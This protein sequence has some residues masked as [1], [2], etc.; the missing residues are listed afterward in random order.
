MQMAQRIKVGLLFNY[1]TNWVAG[2]YYILNLIHAV[3]KL[4]DSHKPEFTILSH[5]EDEFKIARETGYPYLSFS[6]LLKADF[7]VR[8][9]FFERLI[10][11]ISRTLGKQDW[12]FKSQSSK[13]LNL[14][15]DALFPASGLEYFSGVKRRIFWIPDFQDHFLPHLFSENEIEIRKKV[16]SYIAEK[17]FPVVFSS[18]DARN[19]FRM[20][21]P[22]SESDTFVLKFAVT[23]PDFQKIDISI[24]RNKFGII[25]NYFF[26]PNQFWA[27]KNHIVVLQAITILKHEM[28]RPVLVVFSGKQEDYRNPQYFPGLQ[29]YISDN[30]I[31]DCVK[32]LG[33]IDREEQLQIMNNSVAVIQPSL[34]EGWSTVVEDAKA[35]GQHVIVSDIPVHREQITEN[36][37]FFNP[38][39][40]ADLAAKVMTVISTP[41]VKTNVSAYHYNVKTFGGSFLKIVKGEV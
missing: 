10:N 30:N 13:R 26:S 3:N 6:K 17:G 4:D 24:L 25:G 12:Y 8:Y 21:F 11:K 1:D 36:A 39:E 15:L 28:K 16:R 9:S 29:K 5:S 20:I 7:E 22:H 23:H 27:H 35:M 19:H 33:F 31:S 14:N 18:N 40:P 37:T 34:F 32:F 41:P 2:A 38:H